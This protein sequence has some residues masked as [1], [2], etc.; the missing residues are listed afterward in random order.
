VFRKRVVDWNIMDILD[1]KGIIN[2]IV[3]K[4]AVCLSKKHGWNNLWMLKLVK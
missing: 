2:S 4:E 1:K 3:K